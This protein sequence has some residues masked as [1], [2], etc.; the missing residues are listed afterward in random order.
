MLITRKA[1]LITSPVLD[2]PL[3]GWHRLEELDRRGISP[4]TT[5]RTRFIAPATTVTQIPVVSIW[6]TPMRAALQGTQVPYRRGDAS[7]SS[8]H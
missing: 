6:A 8:R 4:L 2:G 7:L 3:T 5:P 1:M